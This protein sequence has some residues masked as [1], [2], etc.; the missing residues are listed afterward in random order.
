METLKNEIEIL[1]N[2][3]HPNICRLVEVHET[4]GSVYLI[5]ELVEGRPLLDLEDFEPIPKEKR[6][7]I[8]KQIS[9]V[10]H[11]LKSKSIIHRDIK[12]D[13]VLL[14]PT[15]HIKVIDFGL[16]ISENSDKKDFRRVGTPGFIAPEVINY[17]KGSLKGYGAE[18]DI[19]SLGIMLYCAIVGEHPFDGKDYQEVLA[20]NY[21]AKINFD[22][23]Q[24]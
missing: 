10:L 17:K 9:S 18:S 24:I 2:L 5:M 23:S 15:G 20:N 19:Y 21:Q 22:K 4:E 3:D 7:P 12:P 13:N 8:F 16:S 6:I 1:R 11:Y 14:T